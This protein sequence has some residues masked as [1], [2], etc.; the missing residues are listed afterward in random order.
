VLK[1]GH[2]GASYVGGGITWCGFTWTQTD[3]NANNVEKC[4]CPSRYN[5]DQNFTVPS[6]ATN[7]E[8]WSNTY[9]AVNLDIRR[10]I[11]FTNFISTNYYFRN[12]QW[13]MDIDGA[14]GTIVN[15]RDNRQLQQYKFGNPT[16]FSGTNLYTTYELGI[17]YPANAAYDPTTNNYKIVDQQ[18]GTFTNSNG[19][20]FSFSRGT[21]W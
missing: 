16:A 21:N 14:S 20:E 15:P 12:K 2:P 17:L 4:A 19:V 3:I 13:F 9:G 11:F 10:Q 1:I 8:W 6:S 5:L 18:F 7:R